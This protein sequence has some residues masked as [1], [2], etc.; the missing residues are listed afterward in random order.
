M[1]LKT[2]FA[3]VS[4]VKIYQVTKDLSNVSQGNLSISSYFTRIKNLWDE[5]KETVNIPTCTY[6]PSQAIAQL[7]QNQ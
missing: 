5:Y 4:G 6:G 3:H 2:R 7:M 1:E